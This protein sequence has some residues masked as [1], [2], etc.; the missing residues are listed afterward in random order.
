MAP[1]MLCKTCKKNK[2]GETSSKTNDFRSKFA[3]IL[4]ASESTRMRMEESVPKYHEDHIAGK[5]DNSLQHYSLVHKFLPVP[6]AMKIP[7]AKATVVR[8]CEKFEEVPAWDITKVRNESHVIDEARKGHK[9]SFCLTD[10][11]FSCRIGDKAPKIQRSS[12]TPRRQSERWFWILCSIHWTRIIS[13]TKMTAA[14]VIDT[15]SRLPGCDG[16]AADAVSVF[17]QV[18][19]RCSTIIEKYQIGMSRHLDSCTT[20]QMAKIMVQYGVNSW[21]NWG[22]HGLQNPRTTTFYCEAIAECQRSRIDTENR[23]PPEPTCSSTRPTTE[24]I[25]WS[26]QWKNQNKWFMKLWT[27]NSANYLFDMEP[28]TQCKVC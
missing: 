7:A 18:N 11:H 22:R 5:E 20:T 25:I 28:K 2:H 17:T 23:E 26:L 24:S 6:Q 15:I 1:A 21:K 10:G 8:E 4:E 13:I 19:G 16:Q 9:S 14:K 12:C 27:S 3:C